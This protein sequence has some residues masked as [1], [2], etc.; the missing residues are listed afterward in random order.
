MNT[1]SWASNN[2]GRDVASWLIEYET[3]L[4]KRP[5]SRKTYDNKIAMLRVLERSL[6]RLKMNRVTPRHLIDFIDREYVQ[7]DK[8]SAAKGAH[9]LLRDI[10]REAWLTGWIKYSPAL[11]L[12]PPKEVVKRSR[13]IEAEFMKIY[14]RSKRVCQPYMPHALE[15]AL[16][17]GQRRSDICKMRRS[18]IYD[19]YLHIEQQKTG[20]KIALPLNLY[21]PAIKMTLGYVIKRCPGDD[22]LL[23]TG[24][25]VMPWSLT[26]GF[27]IARESAYPGAWRHPPTFQ[28]IRSLSERI[29]RDAGIDTQRL[30]GHKSRFMTDKYNDDRGREYK[31]LILYTVV[32][33]DNLQSV[34]YKVYVIKQRPGGSE[35]VAGSETTTHYPAAAAAGFWAAYHDPRWQT[36]EHLLLLTHNHQQRAAY[37]FCS[38]PGE[39]DYVAPDQ[40][41]KL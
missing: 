14:K 8:M 6:G 36:P 30:L 10:F 21:C 18:D 20:A 15:L 19:G 16:V 32:F 41:I 27:Q 33:F 5:Y 37:R 40:E 25:Q 17:S 13:L 24:G 26:Y 9:I 1:P 35:R 11:P 28:E 3:I 2:A 39:R 29:Y 12:R 23:A 38:S 4:S 22:Y 7:R 31:R 34:M